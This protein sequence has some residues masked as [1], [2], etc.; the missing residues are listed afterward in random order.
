MTAPTAEQLEA[1]RTAVSRLLAA[2]RRLRRREQRDTESGLTSTHLRALHLLTEQ[3][4]ATVGALAKAADLTPASM[5]VA[6]DQLEARGLVTRQRDVL[7]RRQCFIT[8]TETGQKIVAA[9][10]AYWRDRMAE[11]FADVPSHK[12]AASIS[13]IARV[14]EVMEG[15][16]KGD[17]E[18]TALGEQASA[19]R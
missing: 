18:T 12:I 9:K 19:G 5:T 8:L 1:L 10:Q 4:Q 6:I 17:A 16:E 13:V 14:V 11:L 7:D 15:L 3:P 2:D